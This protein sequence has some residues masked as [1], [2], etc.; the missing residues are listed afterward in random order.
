MIDHAPIDP[1]HVREWGIIDDA[2]DVIFI[3][4]LL[5]S[6]ELRSGGVRIDVN[7]TQQV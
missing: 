4:G 2:S 5:K 6:Y 1:Y 3:L 7:F